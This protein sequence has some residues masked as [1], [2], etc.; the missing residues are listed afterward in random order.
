VLCTLPHDRLQTFQHAAQAAG[1]VVAVIGEIV[2]RASAPRFLDRHGNEI[3]LPRLSY[4]H[5]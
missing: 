1:V 3:A 5:F 2:T 4:S